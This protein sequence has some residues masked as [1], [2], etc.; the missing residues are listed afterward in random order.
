[1]YKIFKFKFVIFAFVFILTLFTLN[2]CIGKKL[3]MVG[4]DFQGGVVLTFNDT[5]NQGLIVSK[6]DLMSNLTWLG[7]KN[8][9]DTS[10]YM[11]Y[12]DWRMPTAKELLLCYQLLHFKKIGNFNVKTPYW[13]NNEGKMGYFAWFVDFSNGKAYESNEN[14]VALTRAVRDF[15]L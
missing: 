2:F 9:C 4:S 15:K 12:N 10:T 14:N 3:P 6:V 5:L 11:G 1:M 7:S 8:L 13:G